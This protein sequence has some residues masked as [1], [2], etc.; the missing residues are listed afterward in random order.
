MSHV[1]G[2][3]GVFIK[4]KKGNKELAVW[5][6]R[7]LGVSVEAW[8]GAIFSTTNFNSNDDGDVAWMVF[9][10]QA[11]KFSQTQSGFIINYRV[12]DLVGLLQNLSNAGISFE[13]IEK[14]EQGS[15]AWVLDPEGNKVELWEPG[16]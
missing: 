1:V 14:T 7:Y 6:K 9:D 16:A 4:S 13:G 11:S 15:F 3:G 2:I 12:R 8:G 10:S 5:Y